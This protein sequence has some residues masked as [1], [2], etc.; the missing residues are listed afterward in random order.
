MKILHWV[1]LLAEDVAKRI[2]LCHEVGRRTVYNYYID[3]RNGK[4]QQWKEINDRSEEME[5]DT[6]EA[7]FK[8]IYGFGSFKCGQRGKDKQPFILEDQESYTISL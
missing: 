3:W 2:G 5:D 6:F 8:S 1:V 7:L 4:A